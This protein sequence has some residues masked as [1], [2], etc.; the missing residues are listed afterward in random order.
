MIYSQIEKLK[1][2]YLKMNLA[3]KAIKNY[4]EQKGYGF[5]NSFNYY[6]SQP[7]N[8]GDLV[9]N[10]EEN[11]SLFNYRKEPRRFEVHMI[12]FTELKENNG[13]IEI[14]SFNYDFYEKKKIELKHENT[15]IKYDALNMAFA[16]GKEFISLDIAE[17]LKTIAREDIS[18]KS[19]SGCNIFE[20]AQIAINKDKGEIMQKRFQNKIS[21]KIVLNYIQKLIFFSG[22]LKNNFNNAQKRF[23]NIIKFVKVNSNTIN[24]DAEKEI[25]LFHASF[26]REIDCA[27]KVKKEYDFLKYSGL[28][29]FNLNELEEPTIF[30][31]NDILLFE[32]KD[33]PID[34]TA[35]KCLN[36]N[37]NVLNGHI[38]LLKK[39]PA[40]KDCRFFYIG[41]Q[42]AKSEFVRIFDF[43]V[44]EEIRKKE[45][46]GCLKVKLFLFVEGKIFNKDFRKENPEK[47]KILDLLKD[48]R[49]KINDKINGLEI[50]LD[51]LEIRLDGLEA[52]LNN[53]G[54]K[55]DKLGSMIYGILAIVVFLVA[56]IAKMIMKK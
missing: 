54:N 24:L 11:I 23:P 8:G 35:L 20:R 44:C 7:E 18:D 48:E 29:E 16:R 10:L 4:S 37:Y 49:Q 5:E 12:G 36:Y 13:K 25:Y 14:S 17:K 51:G 42:E 53:I 3:G 52:K 45:S 28:K 47:M 55:L 50:R 38:K 34:N 31:A 21:K 43:N 33:S 2:E 30:K 1:I 15:E 39:D 22:Y 40:F 19:I 27:Y 41:I 9:E 26:I 6:I 56:L 32:L 46:S